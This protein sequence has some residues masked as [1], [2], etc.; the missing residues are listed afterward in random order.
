MS[1]AIYGML[2]AKIESD[3]KV[4]AALRKAQWPEEVTKEMKNA[5]YALDLHDN[6]LSEDDVIDIY[7]TLRAVALRTYE[8]QQENRML[9]VDWY[10]NNQTP[11]DWLWQAENKVAEA[12]RLLAAAKQELEL[13]T[14]EAAAYQKFHGIGS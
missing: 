5:I 8:Q 9:G 10:R 3:A 14:R 1:D 7:D 12:E 13:A 4:I 2:E 6:R 11:Q